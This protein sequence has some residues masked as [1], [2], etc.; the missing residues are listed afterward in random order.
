MAG[1]GLV[2][3]V[4]QGAVWRVH[5]FNKICPEPRAEASRFGVGKSSGELEGVVHC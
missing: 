3:A 1:H 5:G 4:D 2:A